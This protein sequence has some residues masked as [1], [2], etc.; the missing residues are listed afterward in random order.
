MYTPTYR[1]FSLYTCVYAFLSTIHIQVNDQA[2]SSES[3]FLQ[4]IDRSM[5]GEVIIL[6][7][8]RNIPTPST[9]GSGGSIGSAG[10]DRN[11]KELTLRLRL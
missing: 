5:S 4:A 11:F 8:L 1:R 6:T 9:S 3:D 2:V 7:I 10:G